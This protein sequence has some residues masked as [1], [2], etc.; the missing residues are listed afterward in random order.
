MKVI[1]VYKFSA[2]RADE[3]CD[4]LSVAAETQNNAESALTSEGFVDIKYISTSL[5]YQSLSN[6][7]SLR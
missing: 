6:E 1:S 5:I 2:L 3:H 7:N 4:S